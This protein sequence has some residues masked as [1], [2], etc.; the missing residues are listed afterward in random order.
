MPRGGA[1]SAPRHDGPMDFADRLYERHGEARWVPAQERQRYA[2][3][4]A[5]QLRA[6]R[7]FA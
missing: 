6:P 3:L 1:R 2:D 4:L 5:Q 7:T